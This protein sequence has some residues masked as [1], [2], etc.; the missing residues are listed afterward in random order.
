MDKWFT[1][2]FNREKDGTRVEKQRIANW[3]RVD[4]TDNRVTDNVEGI[5][6]LRTIKSKRNPSN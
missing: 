1:Y 2:G 5:M 4:V 3:I 6:L